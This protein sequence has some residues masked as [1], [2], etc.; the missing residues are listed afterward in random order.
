MKVE[1]SPTGGS[2]LSWS[3]TL[4][5]ASQEKLPENT[6][7]GC[8]EEGGSWLGLEHE[9]YLIH[10]PAD[11]TV[12]VRL[13]ACATVDPGFAPLTEQ[14]TETTTSL[15]LYAALSG[16]R[17]GGAH[18]PDASVVD[19]SLHMAFDEQL[20]ATWNSDELATDPPW[21]SVAW[22]ESEAEYVSPTEGWLQIEN[23]VWACGGQAIEHSESTVRI[24]WM[25]D[26]TVSGPVKAVVDEP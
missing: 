11:P 13:G 20:G 1:I 25:L 15:Y 12:A 21:Q 19:A 8:R 23:V 22:P 2:G 5:G 10:D 9:G 14:C 6:Y 17:A 4:I 24:E 3:T 16:L 26:D 7:F 18:Y